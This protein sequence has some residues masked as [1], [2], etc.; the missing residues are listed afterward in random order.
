MNWL[1]KLTRTRNLLLIGGTI[2]V[3]LFMFWSD[4][5]GGA[6]TTTLAAQL[7]TP[8]I[9]VWFAHLARKALFDYADMQE[10]YNKAKS[11][12]L[13]AAIIFASMCLV[14][15]ALLG[16]LGQQVKAEPRP[17]D[18]SVYIPEQAKLYLPTLRSEQAAY[19]E[20]HTRPFIL[21]H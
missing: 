12:A 11:S 4:P 10:M 19:W 1:K 3:A 21:E 2:L 13:G 9:A 18:V 15:F 6:L 16:L 8:V 17:T 5:N 7:A 14:L 20:D